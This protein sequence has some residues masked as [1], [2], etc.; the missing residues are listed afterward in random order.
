MLLAVAYGYQDMYCTN[1]PDYY[2]ECRNQRW[3]RQPPDQQ[4]YL[5][6]QSANSW[7]SDVVPSN[8]GL[9]DALKQR[10][11]EEDLV[12]LEVLLRYRGIRTLYGLESLEPTERVVLLCKARLLYELL[13]VFPS[14]RKNALKKLFGDGPQMAVYQGSRSVV[15]AGG[16]PYMTQQWASAPIGQSH[17]QASMNQTPGGLERLTQPLSDDTILKRTFAEAL[18]GAREIVGLVCYEECLRRLKRSDELAM[19][20]CLEA[21]EALASLC[22]KVKDVRDPELKKALKLANKVVRD[23]LLWRCAGNALGLDSREALIRAFEA[24]CCHTHCDEHTVSQLTNGYRRILEELANGASVRNRSAASPVDTTQVGGGTESATGLQS[25]QQQLQL[26]VTSISAL[27]GGGSRASGS[28]SA[29]EGMKTDPDLSDPM[30]PCRL[31]TVLPHPADPAD[32]VPGK[33]RSLPPTRRSPGPHS[34]NAVTSLQM[35]KMMEM[36]QVMSH[37]L[38]HIKAQISQLRLVNA[39]AFPFG[40]LISPDND[41]EE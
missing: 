12:D 21:A 11:A 25:E 15:H 40:S 18:L 13:E 16:L 27:K 2:G 8:G 10:L 3:H 20:S 33:G 4:E 19:A 23:I 39:P 22:I 31:D 32:V 26:Q 36:M 28:Q 34:R 9:S 5:Y 41:D 7:Y 6:E 35:A 1:H 30:A 17:P 29:A 24:A 37:N 38:Q 14:Y